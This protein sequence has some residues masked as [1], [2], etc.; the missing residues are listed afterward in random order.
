MFSSLKRPHDRK[1]SAYIGTLLI[2]LLLVVGLPML[3]LGCQTPQPS[4]SM[5][6]TSGPATSPEVATTLQTSAWDGF[7]SVALPIPWQ[8]TMPDGIILRI[9]QHNHLGAVHCG[10]PE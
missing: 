3:L 10:W 1:P 6:P 7:C 9:K 5:T 2:V 8:A 4:E